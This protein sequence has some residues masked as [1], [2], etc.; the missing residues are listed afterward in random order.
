MSKS[1][2]NQRTYAEVQVNDIFSLDGKV[3]IITGGNGGI[4][5]AIAR[6]LASQGS[7][8]VIAARNK[9][10]TSEASKEIEHD[11]GVRVLGLETDVMG[12]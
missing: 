11:F 9:T 5:K 1:N 10:K 7:G 6:A 3:A 2:L 12:E 4:G 8:I